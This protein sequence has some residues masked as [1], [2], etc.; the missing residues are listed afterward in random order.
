MPRNGWEPHVPTDYFGLTIPF[1]DHCGVEPIEAGE[2]VVRYRLTMR[3]I[4]ENSIG[5][6]H[7]GL[8]L[9]L[10]DMALGAAAR[11]VVAKD[12]VVMTVDMQAAFLSPGRG[13][14]EARGRVTKAGR[15]L[16]FGEGEVVGE[17]G[18]IV[19][20]ATG[21]FRPTPRRREERAGGDA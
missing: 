9:T 4:H 18:E 15:S 6:A 8:I 1:A 13:V 3:R 7:G 11:S 19:A 5:V 20:R 10:L 21:L 12:W 2:G 16:I 14:L 17:D